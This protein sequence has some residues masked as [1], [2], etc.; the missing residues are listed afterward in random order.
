MRRVKPRCW[1]DGTCPTP[2]ACYLNGCRKQ[3]NGPGV[4]RAGV[5][6]S[7]WILTQLWQRVVDPPPGKGD[8][9]V[10]QTVPRLGGIGIS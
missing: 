10:V 5:V 7:I 9:M 1:S 3:K 6:G 4:S 2:I 8:G